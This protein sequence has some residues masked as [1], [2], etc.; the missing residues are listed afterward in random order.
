MKK[1]RIKNWVKNLLWF[2]ICS[3]LTA[4]LIIHFNVIE[5]INEYLEVNNIN[6]FNLFIEKPKVKII[7]EESKTRPIA[8]S[9]NNNHSA[10][11]LSGLQDAYI[12][13]ELI[14]EGGITRLLAFYKDANVDKI[15]SVRSARHYFLDYVLEN[16]AIF[17]H[18]GQSPEAKKDLENLNI[19]N[20]NGLYTSSAFKRDR[21]LK[22]ASEHTAFT[23]TSLITKAVDK[24]KYRTSSEEMLLKYK[25]TKVI[26]NQDDVIQATD[27]TLKYSDYQT[28]SY[29]YNEE[30]M[31][32]ELFMSNK[33][34]KDLVTKQRQGSS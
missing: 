2:I 5:K 12:V 17:V 13:Y 8:V 6:F 4:F 29:K 27:I 20:I 23:S 33:Q 31:V 28:T 30:K 22:R 11:P 9:I 16:D 19:N 26:F 24:N 3:L 21:T 32:Y 10:W 7:D 25:A 18:F 14:A 1:R 34:Q 15:G